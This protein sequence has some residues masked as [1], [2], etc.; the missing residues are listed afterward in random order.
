MRTLLSVGEGL[1]INNLVVK[2]VHLKMGS[3]IL[4]YSV[5]GSA[6]CLL[7][8]DDDVKMMLSVSELTCTS[9]IKVQ[10]AVVI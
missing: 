5:V 6:N 10:I 3:F 7:D 2:F 8:T 4:R 9:I 1:I